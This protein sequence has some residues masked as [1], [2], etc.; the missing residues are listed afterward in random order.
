ML[1]PSVLKAAEN[2]SPMNENERRKAIEQS[3]DNQIIF[4]I[5][6][7]FRRD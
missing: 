6:E 3:S 2:F 1:L 7:H 5:S 4:P